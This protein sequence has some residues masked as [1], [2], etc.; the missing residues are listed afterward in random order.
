[1]SNDHSL[2]TGTAEYIECYEAILSAANLLVQSHNESFRTATNGLSPPRLSLHP[3]AA[4]ISFLRTALLRPHNI[5]GF[6]QFAEVIPQASF[7]RGQQLVNKSTGFLT[8]NIAGFTTSTK[9]GP[10]L[11]T[12][13]HHRFLGHPNNDAHVCASSLASSHG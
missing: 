10:T 5:P 1:M 7:H 4:L 9:R 3:L 12:F 8:T 6:S 2:Y 13:H 11:T